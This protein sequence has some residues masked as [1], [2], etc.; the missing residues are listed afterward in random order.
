M[1]NRIS[2]L[3]ESHSNTNAPRLK[4]AVA[5]QSQLNQRLVRLVQHLHLLIPAIRSSSIRPEE[6][7]LRSVLESIEEEVRRPTGV[8]RLKG[9]L[10]EFW[11]ILGSIEAARE[12]ERNHRESSVEWAVVDQEGLRR[13]TQVSCN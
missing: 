5:L 9:K 3:T 8:G 12:R 1:K 7:A 2:N 6:E 4:R 13:L 10:S 11:A